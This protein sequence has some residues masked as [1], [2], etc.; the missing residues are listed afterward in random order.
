MIGAD[1]GLAY[2][3][4][5]QHAEAQ[6]DYRAALSASDGDEARRRL[7]LSLAITGKKA[8]ALSMLSP[9]MARGDAAGA[10]TRA[11]VLALTGDV[12]G[13]IWA[14]FHRTMRSHRL[15]FRRL[16][17]TQ[18]RRRKATMPTAIVSA[19]SSAGCR[20]RPRGRRPSRIRRHQ[21]RPSRNSSHRCH[22]RRPPPPRHASS[23]SSLRA[24]RTLQVSRISSTG[25]KVAI[26]TCSKASPATSLRSPGVRD[27][28]SGRS[29]TAR[30]PI[31]SPRIL[32]RFALTPLRGRTSLA[33]RSGN[34]P[35][36]D[37]D[38]CRATF[39]FARQGPS[40]SRCRP[41][42]SPRHFPARPRPDYSLRL[43]PAPAPQDAGLRRP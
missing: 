18:Q 37:F 2:D 27:C 39:S 9:L 8:E 41:A 40:G 42:R 10:R 32:H 16:R 3:L 21:L 30:K 43:V 19:R 36:N 38:T 33:R 11:F 26:A 25:S 20:R 34:C 15:R 5:G 13:A 31:S 35:P 29:A 4:I 12:N 1:R 7:S 24:E 22:G 23:G 14:S 28:S 6:A 17:R